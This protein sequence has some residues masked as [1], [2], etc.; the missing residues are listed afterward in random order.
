MEN[1]WRPDSLVVKVGSTGNPDGRRSRCDRVLW[2]WHNGS[3]FAC[4][5]I[6]GMARAYKDTFECALCSQKIVYCTIEAPTLSCY[7]QTGYHQRSKECWYGR[8]A[9]RNRSWC[10]IFLKENPLENVTS[11]RRTDQNLMAII[12]DGRVVKSRVPSLSVERSVDWKWYVSGP[13]STLGMTT[14][15]RK[16]W[17]C[18]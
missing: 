4:A 18:A 14:L 2:Y 1:G 3:N 17:I 7:S 16:S 5:N 13:S 9:G 12:K 6:W 10:I 8:A 15:G 11:F